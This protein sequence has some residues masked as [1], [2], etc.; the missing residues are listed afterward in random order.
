MEEKTFVFIQNNVSEAT[1]EEIEKA[2]ELN[3]KDIL[4]TLAYL[5]KIPPKV[6]APETEWEKRR[7]I[8]DAHDL[9]MQKVLK[10]PKSF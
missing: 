8:C 7:D 6:K 9:E 1:K 2:Y 10:A 5:M 4:C 3:N